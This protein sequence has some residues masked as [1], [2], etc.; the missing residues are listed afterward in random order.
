MKRQYILILAVILF[1]LGPISKILQFGGDLFIISSLIGL[2]LITF[3]AF[4]KTK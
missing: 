1:L 3:L 4:K 2:A